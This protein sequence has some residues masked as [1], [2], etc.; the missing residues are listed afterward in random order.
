MKTLLVCLIATGIA[1]A[2]DPDGGPPGSSSMRARVNAPSDAWSITITSQSNLSLPWAVSLR[3][4]DY[5]DTFG[6]VLVTDYE[7]D[8]MFT[9][10]PATGNKNA[11]LA[12]PPEIPQVLGVC[13]YQAA[14]GNYFYINDWQDGT[15]IYEY[16]T[17]TGSWSLAFAN[18]SPEP[19]GMDMDPDLYIWEIDA[20]SHMLYMID[21][22]GSVVD[23]W[24]LG[25]LPSGYACACCVYPY[26][27]DLVL[28][29]GGYYFDNFYFYLYDGADL[30]YMGNAPV[31]QSY[32]ASYGV[33]Y[34]EDTDSFYWI[35][36]DSGSSYYLCEFTVDIEEALQPTTWGQI[37]AGL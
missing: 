37:K 36:R 2:F 3:G 19:R 9:V 15:D 17:G 22:T 16:Y 25:E 20:A 5:A 13:H 29:I 31:P 32:Y 7:Q 1:L 28:L 35:W 33:G 6:E 18:P 26:E 30:E 27:G 8:S 12:C 11:G 24:T 10:D 23:S 14:G 34:S 21:L 4:C